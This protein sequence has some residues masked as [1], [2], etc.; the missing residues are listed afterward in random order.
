[1]IPL[2]LQRETYLTRYY[3]DRCQYVKHKIFTRLTKKNFIEGQISR[4]AKGGEGDLSDER[5]KEG[6]T[7]RV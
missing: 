7:G 2:V 5:L 6:K 1:M 4:K 3:D